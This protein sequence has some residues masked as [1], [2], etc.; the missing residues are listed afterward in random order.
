MYKDLFAKKTTSQA[1]RTVRARPRM[2]TVDPLGQPTRV[3]VQIN[4]YLPKY[5]LKTSLA[6]GT[7]VVLPSPPFSTKIV[8]TIS[9]FS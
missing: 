3:F 1:E 4:L 8:K 6:M 2:S 7:A 5:Q 9:G